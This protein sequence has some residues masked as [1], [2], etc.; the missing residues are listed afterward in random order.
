MAIR[1]IV[2]LDD[3]LIM[4]ST[5]EGAT[6]DIMTLKP[7]LENLGFLINMEKSIFVH[8]ISGIIVGS[9]TMRFLLLDEEVAVI[10]KDCRHLISRLCKSTFSYYRKVN[11]LENCSSSSPSSLSGDPT[12]EEQQHA[13]PPFPPW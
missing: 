6:K 10:Q 13:P 5:L 1:T 12:F 9:T 2:Y 4:N 8:R 11:F 3:M 7:I